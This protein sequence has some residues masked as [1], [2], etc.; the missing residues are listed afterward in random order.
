MR[1]ANPN[2]HDHAK[3]FSVRSKTTKAPLNCEAFVVSTASL[4]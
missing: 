1:Q 3:P 2:Q 4:S